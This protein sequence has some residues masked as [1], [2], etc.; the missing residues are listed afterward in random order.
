MG[1]Y[2]PN[3]NSISTELLACDSCETV[4][5]IRCVIKFNKQFLCHNCKSGRPKENEKT[6]EKNQ[7]MKKEASDLFSMFG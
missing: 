4:G 3:C 1:I 2:C 6:V 5:C 7:E